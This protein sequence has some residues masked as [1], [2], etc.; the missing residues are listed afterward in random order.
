MKHSRFM[1]KHALSFL[2]AALTITAAAVIL[3]SCTSIEPVPVVLPEDIT[4]SEI[5][6]LAQSAY[7]H[8]R[9][10][11]AISYYNELIE[12]FGS[13]DEGMAITG[14]YEIAHIYIKLKKYDLAKPL[15]QEVID[16]YTMAP[17]GSLP[18]AYLKLAKKD[19]QKIPED[20]N[21]EKK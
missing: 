20:K 1:R 4:A 9:V 17:P 11:Q 8:G 5:I 12:R 16:S 10:G 21:S 7:D 19:M 13:A 18:A 14:K 3:P 6:Q 2:F 15:L